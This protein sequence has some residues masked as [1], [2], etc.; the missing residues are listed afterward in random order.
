MGGGDQSA[1]TAVLPE[2]NIHENFH[3]LRG[4]FKNESTVNLP[5]LRWCSWL[6]C[7]LAKIQGFGKGIQE[8]YCSSMQLQHSEVKKM[9]KAKEIQGKYVFISQ[10]VSPNFRG[11]KIERTAWR[12]SHGCKNITYSSTCQRLSLLYSLPLQL[13]SIISPSS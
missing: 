2:L 5:L 4:T 12:T 10:S 8:L 3:W 1:I 11:K 13:Y 6:E 9:E 7:N